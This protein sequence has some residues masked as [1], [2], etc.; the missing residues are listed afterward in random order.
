MRSNYKEGPFETIEQL[1]LDKV[2]KEFKKLDDKY[3]DCYNPP[4]VF[5]QRLFKMELIC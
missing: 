3:G 1:G 5:H 4:K 2:R